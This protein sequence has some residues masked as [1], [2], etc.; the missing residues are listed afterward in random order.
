M[1]LQETKQAADAVT[2]IENK[3]GF[4][5]GSIAKLI[6]FVKQAA[7]KDVD[8][9][10]KAVKRDQVTIKRMDVAH[11][12][13]N[14]Q[15]KP[16][17]DNVVTKEAYEKLKVDQELLKESKERLDKIKRM[18]LIVTGI[19]VAKYSAMLR[20]GEKLN[21]D[22]EQ[23]NRIKAAKRTKIGDKRGLKATGLDNGV[24]H[25]VVQPLAN[26]DFGNP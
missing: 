18:E 7:V 20:K 25:R 6:D 19:E 9:S 16:D 21:T 24:N 26:G 10:D 15:S 11:A 14:S 22:V 23:M 5:P 4:D 1:K 12:T 8:L 2:K 3:V 17:T 13:D